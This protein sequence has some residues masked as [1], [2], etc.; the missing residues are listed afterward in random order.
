MTSYSGF[1]V[2]ETIELGEV[3]D[4]RRAVDRMV[5]AYAHQNEMGEFS[6]R[7]LLPRGEKSNT[8]AK[9]IGIAFQGEFVLAL[10]KQNLVP[11]VREVRYVHD[12]KHY[13][14]LLANPEVFKQFEKE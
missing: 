3:S 1:P 4:I 5:E 9:R 13:G 14:W 7:I 8:K 6:Y 10:R 12:D 2:H 11:N